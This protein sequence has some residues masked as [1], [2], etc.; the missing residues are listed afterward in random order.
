MTLKG[1]LQNTSLEEV[2][3][4]LQ[5]IIVISLFIMSRF[6]MLNRQSDVRNS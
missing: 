2:L 1:G 5:S 6:Q 4:L 3:L